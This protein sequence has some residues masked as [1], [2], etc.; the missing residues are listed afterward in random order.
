MG[1]PETDEDIQI[2]KINNTNPANRVL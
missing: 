2:T 1:W